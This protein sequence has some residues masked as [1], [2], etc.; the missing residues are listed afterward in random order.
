MGFLFQSLRSLLK[1]FPGVAV[2]SVV[3]VL[4]STPLQIAANESSSPQ[5]TLKLGRFDIDATPP[6]G[7]H[8]AYDVMKQPWDLGLRAR[9]VVLLSD[10]IPPVV[11]CSVDWIGI[12][13]AA[14]DAFR[15]ALA[16]AAGTQPSHVAVHTVHQHDAPACDFSAEA[17]LEAAGLA[18]QAY[19]GTFARALLERLAD[20][21]QQAV[22]DSQ[23][24]T[25]IGVGRAQVHQVASNRR[26]LGEDG[27]VRATRYTATKDPEL[28]AEPEGLIDPWVTVLSFWNQ[29]APVAVLSYYAVHPQSYY[30][31]GIANPDFP[32]LARFLRQLEVPQALHVH[33]NGA[34]GN[35]G[36][37]KY[38]DGSPEH[39][40]R[41]AERL[42]DGMKRAWDRT[43]RQA[44]SSI[45][46]AFESVA[47]PPAEHLNEEYL[48]AQM[49]GRDAAFF[50][51]GGAARLAWLR[52][53][54]AGNLLDL[55]LL[56]LGSVRVLHLPGETFV[57]YQLAAQAMRP[58]LT[59]AVAG[60]GNYAP[61][62]VGTAEAYEQGGYETSPAASN[63]DARSETILI[64]AMRALLEHE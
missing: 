17:I 1:R 10:I 30:R 55:Q 40:L 8:L 31:T 14:H 41:L 36:A 9:G 63:V 18:T 45:G 53:A 35:L 22:A 61:G 25:D 4:L 16:T 64:Q 48:I 42:A 33:F 26:I 50:L 39:R 37:G 5:A 46:W 27:K 52:R 34:G 54:Q 21:V 24:V 28:R 60:Y 49:K 58:D 2:L 6:V 44:V 13:N 19:D 12:G 38:N 15:R 7:S 47:L 32:G 57:E 59:V 29:T 3:P 56:K 20:A 23:P 43:E 62:Y 51:Q 11:L